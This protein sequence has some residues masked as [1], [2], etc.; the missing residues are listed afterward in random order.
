MAQWVDF[1]TFARL[2]DDKAAPK[3]AI[4][5]SCGIASVFAL[6]SVIRGLHSDFI[7]PMIGGAGLVLLRSSLCVGVTFRDPASRRGGPIGHN[8]SP[9]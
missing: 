3:A 4:V 1:T 6:P 8:T 9:I 5:L 2:S 7:V